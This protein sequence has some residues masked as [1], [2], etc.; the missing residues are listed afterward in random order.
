MSR[1][2][3]K[4][5]CERHCCS[6]FFSSTNSWFVCFYKNFFTD[7]GYLTFTLPVNRHTLL[8]SKIVS[9]LIMDIA[10]IFVALLGLALMV[11]IGQQEYVFGGELWNDLNDVFRRLTT[12][13]VC[14]LW[15]YLAEGLVIYLL[16]SLSSFL[17]LFLCITFGSA[18]AKKAKLVAA[19]CI[20]F[21][22]S[23]TI[24]L[25]VQLLLNFCIPSLSYWMGPL[26]MSDSYPLIALM[27]LAVIMLMGTLCAFLYAL[28]N[29]MLARKLNL[30]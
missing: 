8:K 13:Q 14:Y 25:L 17:F 16:I 19:I 11:C 22:A 21:V 7:A 26:K 4:V 2:I 3:C 12:E 1:F 5:S 29:R 30:S 28:V 6:N 23:G 15:L 27:L 20:Y 9:A 10:T 24:S 18:V